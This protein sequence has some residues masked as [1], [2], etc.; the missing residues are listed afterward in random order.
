MLY[1]TINIIVMPA[2]NEAAVWTVNVRS[3]TGGT[4][5]TLYLKGTRNQISAELKLLFNTMTR[6]RE[7]DC[8]CTKV[9]TQ[10]MTVELQKQNGQI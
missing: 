10:T 5:R 6:L 8:M 4:E 2:E 9:E 7:G 1:E 3:E